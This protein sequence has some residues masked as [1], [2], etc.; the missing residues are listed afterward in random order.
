MRKIKE[1][2]EQL[3]VLIIEVA[4]VGTLILIPFLLLSGIMYFLGL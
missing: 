4:L 1:V 2:I 3:L